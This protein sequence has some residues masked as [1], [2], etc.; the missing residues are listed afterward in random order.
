LFGEIAFGGLGS[1][2]Y[3]LIMILLV[4]VFLCGL[5][6]GRTPEYLGRKLDPREIKVIAFYTLIAPAVILPLTALAAA[7]AARRAGL[8][9][10]AGAHGLTAIAVAYA[11]CFAN[12]GLAFGSLNSNC[13]FYNVTTIIAMFA[14]RYLLAVTALALAGFF[15]AQQPRA[16]SAGTLHTD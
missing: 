11:S 15:A 9:A 8:P 3:G 12:N 7:P 10:S 6:I 14:G 1:G 13:L 5:M 4:A 16:A 2:F